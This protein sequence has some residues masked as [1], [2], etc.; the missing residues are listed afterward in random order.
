[1]SGLLAGRTVVKGLVSGVL[2]AISLVASSGVAALECSAEFQIQQLF[3]NGAAWEMCWEEQSRE[4]M[5]LRDL[6]Y[7]SPAG[8]TRRV[9]YQANIAQIHVPYDDDG[10]RF[11]DVSD[12]GLGGNRLNDLMPEDCPEG[13]LIQNGTKDVFCKTLHDAAAL[14]SE[15][16]VRHGQAFTLFSVSHVGA[17]NYIPEWRFFD[18]GTIEPAM[19]AT[20][21]LQR[22][23]NDEVYGWPVRT[24]NSPVGVSHIHNYY[25]RLDF[26]LDGGDDD[27]FEELEFVAGASGTRE[28]VSTRFSN[29]AARSVN[30]ETQRF[31]R[32]YDGGTLNAAGRA[33]S[34]D[35][36]PLETGHRDIGPSFEPWTFNDIY[37]T[38]YRECERFTSHNPAD[39]VAGC[40][41]NGDVT[42][43]V[44]GESIDNNDLV[45][46]FGLTFHHTPRDEDEAYMN[47]HWNRFR[48][49]PRDWLDE[50]SSNAIP[51]LAP[52]ADRQNNTGEIV[53]F[54]ASAT[55][56]DGEA[57]TFSAT[58]LPAGLSMDAAGNVS[59]TLTEAGNYGVAVS[60]ADPLG[61][62]ATLSFS[63]L[64]TDGASCIDCTDFAAV[65]TQSYGRQDFSSG[66]QIE[67]AGGT[68]AL[69]NNT[70]RRGSATY[71]ITPNT[72][73]EFE[74]SSTNKGEIHGIGFDNDHV[75]SQ[76]NIFQLYGTQVF[77]EQ[78]FN[79]YS[80]PGFAAY[81]IPVG[82]YYTG[83]NMSLVFVN[84]HDSGSGN[85][86]FFRNV[87]VYEADGVTRSG[88]SS[89]AGTLTNLALAGSARQTSTLDIGLD[90][91][92]DNAI[93]GN[94][95]GN[96]PADDIAHTNITAESWWEV[97]L[98]AVYDLASV[99]VFKREDCCAEG[100][101]D[102]HVFVS[103]VPFESETV[104]GSL[105]QAGVSSVFFAGPGARENQFALSRSGRY[106]RVQLTQAEHLQIAE[107]EVMG[108]P[109]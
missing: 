108:R 33:I 91:S 17:Y 66:V 49:E 10:A 73:L 58:G 60:V 28:L 35:I 54:V 62:T 19:G 90:F 46:W 56:A 31:W 85:T 95:G 109:Q 55:D 101:A 98:G 24:G 83:S 102:F 63:W 16:E 71:T 4:G 21:R 78:A 22:Y 43:F 69:Q 80:P 38:T 72:V 2:F 67:D 8:V 86:S 89:D 65:P 27:R 50:G 47:T 105:L 96:F 107:V 42:D 1:M 37:A 36:L 29:E 30:P 3:A 106:V 32:V 34:Y 9:M 7:T 64:V 99:S 74:F 70:W 41:P 77:G 6:T 52:I 59:G 15:T 48:L 76:V 68:L 97:D 93:D 23:S 103:D 94:R 57:L 12:F 20:G 87:R 25:W 45:L 53:S 11:H 88:G 75:L 18:N 61:A 84:D 44:S 5:V 81:Q 14:Q 13:T 39:S 104:A 51:V 79:T 100:L 40:L 82:N 26:D 92:A